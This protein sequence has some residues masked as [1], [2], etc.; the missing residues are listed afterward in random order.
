MF[1][2]LPSAPEAVC[3]DVSAGHTAGRT[4][5]WLAA[6]ANARG[7]QSGASSWS[8]RRVSGEENGRRTPRFSGD[9]HTQRIDNRL[10][11]IADTPEGGGRAD[12]DQPRLSG[13]RKPAGELVQQR[14]LAA[15]GLAHDQ[16]DAAVV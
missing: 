4:P 11:R 16:Q 7:A 6:P 3:D 5:L 8:R 13:V 15:A 14:R 2:H 10:V 1:S 9:Q 12:G